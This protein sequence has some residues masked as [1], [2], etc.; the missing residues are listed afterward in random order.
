MHTVSAYQTQR[1]H[2]LVE[3]HP[4]AK[5]GLAIS[6]TSPSEIGDRA[7]VVKRSGQRKKLSMSIS[8]ISYDDGSIGL[9]VGGYGAV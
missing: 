2:L 6:H 9:L 3:L 7:G 5:L 8:K 4:I 1:V